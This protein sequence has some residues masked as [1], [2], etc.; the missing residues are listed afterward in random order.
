[1]VLMKNIYPLP[2]TEWFTH[3]WG[4]QN[5]DYPVGMAQKYW[6]PRL[7]WLD[8][9]W[10]KHDQP[11]LDKF[12]SILH[13][14][15]VLLLLLARG[16]QEA[17]VTAWTAFRV[18]LK[19]VHHGLPPILRECQRLLLSE[20]SVQFIYCELQIVEGVCPNFGQ[21]HMRRAETSWKML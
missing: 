6:P 4:I 17:A 14:S 2:Q 20:L 16:S 9:N 19:M 12:H 10:T 13:G 18:C 21:T 7:E 11:D 15:Q 3:V 5:Y 8:T 1:M